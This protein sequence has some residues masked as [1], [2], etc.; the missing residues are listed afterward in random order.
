MQ[1]PSIGITKVCFGG[2]YGVKCEIN[3]EKL[4]HC[5]NFHIKTKNLMDFG[6]SLEDSVK[7]VYLIE[8]E[9]ENLKRGK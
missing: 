3:G 5:D 6:F 9:F 4:T 7:W 2:F 1:N 8:Q